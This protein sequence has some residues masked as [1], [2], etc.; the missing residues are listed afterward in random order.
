[1]TLRDETIEW[2]KEQFDNCIKWGELGI[3]FNL[4][5]GKIEW[6][7]KIKKITEKTGDCRDP[8]NPT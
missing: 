4:R 7:E 3:I 8:Q 1:M 6:I 2:L 5:D